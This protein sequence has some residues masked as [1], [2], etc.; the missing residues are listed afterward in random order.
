MANG[1][2]SAVRAS[3]GAR[4]P[5]GATLS[6]EI[7]ARARTGA[8]TNRRFAAFFGIFGSWRLQAVTNLFIHVRVRAI[9]DMNSEFV[10]WQG[11]HRYH[12]NRGW[13]AGYP[14]GCP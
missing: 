8:D 1:A 11:F 14:I 4:T 13:L 5:V 6:F 3:T 12:K 7:P 2:E 10:F 9:S